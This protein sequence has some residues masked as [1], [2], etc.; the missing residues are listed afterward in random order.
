M[1]TQI[2]RL[3][4]YRSLAAG[5]ER[6]RT[7][8]VLEKNE[9]WYSK[10]SGF[11]DPFDCNFQ[12]ALQTDQQWSDF[13]GT[14]LEKLGHALAKGAVEL[15]KKFL[16]DR[17]L[18]A[19]PKQRRSEKKEKRSWTI[20]IHDKDGRELDTAEFFNRKQ[21]EHLQRLYRMLDESFGVLSLSEIPDNILM[22]S[23]Y[24][25]NHEGMCL[26]F[27]P[28]LHPSAFPRLNPVRYQDVYPYIPTFFPDVVQLLIAKKSAKYEILLD[29]ANV[30]AEDLANNAA[31][32][33]ETRQAAL[34]IASWFYV[35]SAHWSYEREWRALNAGPGPVRF[36]PRALKGII[37]G[38]SISQANLNC[39]KDLVKRR[40]P[41]VAL[42]RA[43]KK[44][45]QF[46]L[47]IIPL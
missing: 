29:T 35:K 4:K 11:N 39:I 1:K 24:A 22:W 28:R 42:Y 15:G 21:E 46:G 10:A 31:D 36:T 12:I 38:C 44:P 3:Y 32:K 5:V 40:R 33:S 7:L 16:S 20:T 30:L 25:N 8:Q 17:Q 2:P 41:K 34:S 45:R 13:F 9:L 43:V 19:F 37:V 6:D 18:K 26:E 14:G 27:D 47:D 23:H